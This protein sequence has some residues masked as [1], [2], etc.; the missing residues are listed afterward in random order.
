[1]LSENVKKCHQQRFL[2]FRLEFIESLSFHSFYTE[3]F[4]L[5]SYIIFQQKMNNQ[6][7]K[8]KNN[9]GHR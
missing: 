6:T 3:A 1:M 7:R 9:F 2:S 4:F 5:S 8:K